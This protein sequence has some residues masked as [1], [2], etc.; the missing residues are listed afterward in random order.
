MW[1][2]RSPW[3]GWRSA[4]GSAPVHGHLH[5]PVAPHRDPHRPRAT[6]HRTIL[7]EH[8]L[9]RLGPVDVGLDLS[10]LSAEGALDRRGNAL[11]LNRPV[12]HGIA[13]PQQSGHI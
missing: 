5:L 1:A 13:S 11:I 8:V 3:R 4:S 9:A 7:D 6:A 12:V 10:R 2:P